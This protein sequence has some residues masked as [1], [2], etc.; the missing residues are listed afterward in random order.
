MNTPEKD[1]FDGIE[2]TDKRQKIG[3]F[4]GTFDPVHNGHLKVAEAVLEAFALERV[5]FVPAYVPPHKR[6]QALSSVYHRL[7][8]LVL[9]TSDAPRMFVSTVEIDSPT[10]P[11]TIETLERLQRERPEWRLFFMMGADSFRDITSWYE[12]QRILAEYDVIVAT[13]PGYS[14]ERKMGEQIAQ[15]A[16]HLQSRVVD[17][18]GGRLP[19]EESAPHIYLTDYAEVDVAATTLRE[20]AA[21]GGELDRLVPPAVAG[22]IIKYGLYQNSE[23]QKS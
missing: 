14:E 19:V 11:Y 7:A 15:L 6:G 23:C 13:R 18:R 3:V 21:K 5:V 4:G 9:A 12:Y 1:G 22:Y 16:R 2:K 20:V 8:M 10:R 17:L